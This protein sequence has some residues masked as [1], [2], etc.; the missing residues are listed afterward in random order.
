MTAL[1]MAAALPAVIVEATRL[2]KTAYDIPAAVETVRADEI[3]ATG[4]ADAAGALERITPSLT[5]TR[6]GAGN[7]ALAQ[8]AM[9]GWGENG[10]GRT[11]F[12]VDGM[13]LNQA[14]MSAPLLSQIDL[15]GVRRVELM[16]GSAC[17]L[18][19]DAASAG[20]VNVVTEPEGWDEH[21]R[22]QLR[23]GSWETFGARASYS[24][25]S[26][27][28]GVKW[29][30]DG[31]WEHSRGYRAN[32]GWQMWNWRGGL[33]KDFDNGSFVRISSF[34]SDSDYDL[35]GYLPAGAWKRRTRRTASPGD[36]YRRRTWGFNSAAEG[37]VNDENRA[38]LDFSF[39]TSAMKS[40]SFT[41]GSYT[42]YNPADWSA[43]TV[44]WSDD[45]R[46]FYDLY[47]VEAAPQWIN[48]SDVFG[49]SNEI[50]LGS[51]WRWDRLHGTNR[52]RGEYSPDFWSSSGLRRDKYEYNRKSMAFFAQDTLRLCDSLAVE[53]GGRWQRTWNENTALVS[54]R[55][56]LDA[57]AADAAL[58][59][60]PVE[61]LKTYVRLSRYF[62]N[63]F[64][65]ENPYKNYK[66][67]KILSP[68][69][70]WRADVGADWRF[71]REFRVSGNIFVSRTK[72]EIM[73]D[74]FLEGTNVNSPSPVVRGG[75]TVAGAWER[76]KVAGARVGYTFVKAEF[77]GGPYDGN[78]VPM[79]PESTV[80]ASGRVWLWDECFVFGGWRYA[81]A[82]RAYSDFPNGG[83]RLASAGVF[84]A[85]VQYAPEWEWLKG[86]KVGVVVDNLFDKRYADLAVRAQSGG[87]VYYPAAGRSVM[88]TVSFEF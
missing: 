63:P 56:T 65:D 9:P 20:L 28:D 47:S 11:L 4:A 13:R 6:T 19:G 44:E 40:R 7:P 5:V 66:A 1:L 22:V 82:R 41:S 51:M 57:Y 32:G 36:F 24:G 61:G 77:D 46:M 58:L 78:D 74:K 25:G 26:R 62:R 21:G 68:E 30:S 17:V 73:Y 33:R 16:H 42:D 49:L 10:F 48:S 34:W 54:P 70:G 2:E 53:A 55:R 27:A 88:F 87:T 14:D 76:E 60:T 79:A 3:E 52:D 69:T 64:L 43:A 45:Y 23:A 75:F 85:G 29:W 86:L 31:G 84:H 83:S 81:S 50:V 80:V 72:H 15:G 71:A 38:R 37:V 12:L 35:P 39:S 59:F 67:Q 8:V 18:Y